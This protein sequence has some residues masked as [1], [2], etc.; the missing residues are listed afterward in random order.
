[1]RVALAGIWHE[2]NTFD[3]RLTTLDDFRSYQYYEGHDLVDALSGTGTELGGALSAA[4][5]LG[6]QV[7]PLLF[8][9]ALPSG[10]VVAADFD[11]MLGSIVRLARD[12]QPL[13][14]LVLA[15]HGAMTVDGRPD[16]EA[17]IVR[18]VRA[19]VEA[20]PIAVTLDYHAN[21][22]PEL[23]AA[24]DV[25]CGYRTYPH[26]DMADRG[27]DALSSV[28]R[29][30]REGRRPRVHLEKLPLLTLPVEQE[31]ALE[32]MAAILTLVE[33]ACRDADVWTAC[34]LPGFAYSDGG[35]LGFSVYV[36]ADRDPR[37]VA[38]DIAQE[39]WRRRS[40]F[41]MDLLD[42]DS[43]VRAV[44]TAPCPGVLVDVADNVGGG[45]PGDSTAVLHALRRNGA[46]DAVTVVWDPVT[47]GELNRSTGSMDS[48]TV[49]GRSSEAMGPPF[50]ISGPV[51]RHGRVVY[52]R[53]SSYMTGST[54]DMG[55]VAVVHSDVGPVVV[56]GNR[57]VPFDQDHLR[58]LGIEPRGARVLV[59]KGAIAWKAAF[60]EF[61][62]HVAYVKGPGACPVDVAVLDYADR[63]RPL[64]PLEPDALWPVP[65]ARTA[66]QRR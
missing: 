43:A 36:A 62:R 52:E 30:V 63:P 9:A 16:P 20:V 42:A 53:S 35:R 47:A 15:L 32:P 51:T 48:V 31:S 60:G 56:T 57:V 29:A 14:G 41:A 24:A 46:R 44:M 28:V 49:G 26:V 27:R 7:V 61:A 22:S 18:A 39:V 8:A 66:I 19:V 6:I 23:A 10:P 3:D 13:D 1:M 33:G 21:V 4:E 38:L 25:L 37:A 11:R 5:E 34:A 64:Y 17:E 45:S 12:Q 58:V 65:S 50:R 59:A 40:E 2:S 55:E 54:V